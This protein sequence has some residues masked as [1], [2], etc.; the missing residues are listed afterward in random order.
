MIL[1]VSWVW[2]TAPLRGGREAK[3]ALIAATPPIARHRR[4]PFNRANW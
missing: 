2:G 4:V 3:A 1:P